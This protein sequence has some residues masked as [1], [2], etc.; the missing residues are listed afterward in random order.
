MPA[1]T[2]FPPDS[3]ARHLEFVPRALAFG[4]SGRRGLVADL[5]QLEIYLNARAELD[6]LLS[7]LPAQGGI[8]RGSDFYLAHDLRPSSTHRVPVAGGRGGILEAIHR[9]VTDAGL[10]AVNLGAIPTPALA[11]YALARGAGSMMV[12]GSH[13]PFDRNGYKT[14][15]AIGELMKADEAPINARVAE[16]RQQLLGQAAADSAFDVQGMLR[17]P[18]QT[19]PAAEASGARE[20]RQRYVDFFGAEALAGLRVLVYQ[21]SAVG[22][23]L[24]VETLE[25]LGAQVTA[26]GRSETFVPIDTEAVDEATLTALQALAEVE[27]RAGRRFDALVSTDGDS[28][29]PLLVGLDYA[30]DGRVTARFFG[31]DLVGMLVAESLAPD[32]VVVPISCNDAITLG[33]LA[34]VLEPRTRIGSPHVIAGMLEARSRG[35]ARVCGW[36]ANGGFL[37]ATDLHRGARVLRALP[38]RD[39]FLPL[40]SVLEQMKTRGMRM[41]ELFEALPR[42]YSRAG[43]LREFPRARSYKILEACGEGCVPSPPLESFFSNACGFGALVGRNYTDGLRL[44]FSNGDVAHIR[45][46]G[47]AEELR[48]YAVADSQARADEIIRLGLAEPDGILHRLAEAFG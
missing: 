34:S 22:R 4:T 13:I 33:K 30:P 23:D 37:T 3:L 31:G 19:L 2:D 1:P 42:R 35:C 39:A 25:A 9:A 27:S 32:A 17:G 12:T 5:T 26:T 45:P 28:D 20:Y 14:N 36:E 11:A 48:L 24:L 16:W 10:Q 46:S 21:H 7:L 47:N 40:F 8:S 44:Q 18:E 43:L 41:A 29:R 15:T 38:T 6:Y